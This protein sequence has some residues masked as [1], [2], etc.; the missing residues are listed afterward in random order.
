M[1][2]LFPSSSSSSSS[3]DRSMTLPKG[4]KAR[5]GAEGSGIGETRRLRV[6]V[7]RLFDFFEA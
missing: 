7:Q 6:D 2:S 4:A 5:G 1:S 3:V